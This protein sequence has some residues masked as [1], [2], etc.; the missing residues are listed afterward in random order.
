MHADG[1]G[2]VRAGVGLDEDAAQQLGQSGGQ[3]QAADLR[4]AGWT[5]VG[6]RREGDGRT[7]IRA[8][9]PFRTPAEAARISAELSGAHPLFRDFRVTRQRSWLRTRTTFHGRVDPSG[10]LS[11]FSDPQLDAQLGGGLPIDPAARLDR[12]L[13]VEVAVRLP[14]SISSNAPL[15]ASNGAVWRPHWGEQAT[16]SASAV[17]WNLRPIVFGGL[18]VVALAAALVVW[19][20]GRRRRRRSA[21]A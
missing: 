8:S 20:T 21:A 1:S 3:L 10:G 11:S 19:L 4:K 18:A 17:S 13:K 2:V 7:W 6:P 16:L 14:G 5:V 15:Q 12:I 9:K